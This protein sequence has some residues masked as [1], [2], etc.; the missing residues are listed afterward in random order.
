MWMV[1]PTLMVDIDGAVQ[2]DATVT[3]G[4]DD[5]GTMWSDSFECSIVG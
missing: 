2:A 3:V 4:V 5:T 1:V